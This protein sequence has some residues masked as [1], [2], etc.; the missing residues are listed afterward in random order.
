VICDK[1]KFVHFHKNVY[2]SDV[3]SNFTVVWHPEG[4]PM[5]VGKPRD[6]AKYCV[7]ISFH[8]DFSI[9]FEW[10]TLLEHPQI[11]F[12]YQALGLPWLD[13]NY[14]CEV[15]YTQTSR[16]FI[17]SQNNNEELIT[18]IVTHKDDPK[19]TNLFI[20]KTN[21]N[22]C[23][24]DNNN[25]IRYTPSDDSPIFFLNQSQFADFKSIPFVFWPKLKTGYRLTFNVKCHAAENNNHIYFSSTNSFGLSELYCLQSD[26]NIYGIY[27]N[28][29][30]YTYKNQKFRFLSDNVFI[31]SHN[32]KNYEIA[33]FE[34]GSNPILKINNVSSR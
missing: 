26:G 23:I 6:H 13:E 2:T 22:R 18:K 29:H 21:K 30:L 25:P 20:L 3:L 16:I 1:T 17:S 34:I 33:S 28:N 19:Y 27:V 14:Q 11:N 15:V 7:V 4:Y 32:N 31:T 9:T 8:F 12:G 24:S 10:K 5:I